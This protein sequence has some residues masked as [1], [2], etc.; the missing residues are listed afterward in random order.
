MS[1]E[2]NPEDGGFQGFITTG[3][4]FNDPGRLSL[5]LIQIL[6]ILFTCRL[7]AIPFSYLKQPRVIAEVIGGILLGPTALGRWDWFRNTFF[8]SP[9]TMRPLQMLADVG[10]ILFMLLI[11]LELDMRIVRKN[12]R[13]SI[14]ISLAGFLIPFGL[15]VAVSYFFYNFFDFGDSK[16]DFSKFLLFI[17][18]AMSVTALPVLARILTEKK[19]A[20]TRLGIIVLSAAAVDDAT[21]WILLALVIALI[22]ASEPIIS[23]YIFLATLAFGLFM[24]FGVSPILRKLQTHFETANPDSNSD[25]IPSISQPM[26]VITFILTLIASFITNSI[27]IHTMYI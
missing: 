12:I 9:A 25:G 1:S 19:L 24:F 20:Q 2:F 10:L 15:S 18:V 11:G 3:N 5:L 23:L 13:A 4:A 8:Q 14:T 17:G 27:G 21:C 7:I 16:P 22:G 6:I 26:V